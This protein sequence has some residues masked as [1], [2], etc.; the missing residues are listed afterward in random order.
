MPRIRI[1]PGELVLD[2]PRKVNLLKFLHSK[3]IP[4]G[5]ACGGKGLCASCKI[6]V[7]EGA[8]NLSRPNDTETELAE[9]NHLQKDE[10]IACQCKL[11][12]DITITTSYWS[13][14]DFDDRQE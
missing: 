10:R 7:L 8:K 11:L 2:A 5:S 14:G 9:R 3:D 6:N 12:G 1:K 13:E 4:V